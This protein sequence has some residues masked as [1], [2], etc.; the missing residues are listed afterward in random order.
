MAGG[1]F[2]G[3]QTPPLRSVIEA[4]TDPDLIIELID[5]LSEWDDFEVFKRRSGDVIRALLRL[6]ETEYTM[7]FDGVDDI[8]RGEV[9]MPDFKS[10]FVSEVRFYINER[11][12]GGFLYALHDDGEMITGARVVNS[13]TSY[14]EVV[15][16]ELDSY[17]KFRSPGFEPSSW[18]DLKVKYSS[19]EVEIEVDGMENGFPVSEL[20]FSGA[21][22]L[23]IG[24]RNYTGFLEASINY[25]QLSVGPVCVADI[26]TEADGAIQ[27]DDDSIAVIGVTQR[28]DPGLF[29]ALIQSDFR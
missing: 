22:D 6:F 28:K 3:S 1:A 25:V 27:R 12:D 18:V 7:V 4:I 29:E 15:V 19:R 13:A 17:S 24:A 9:S 8:I 21:Y 5:V 10:G 14:I 2:S 23:T 11:S 26:Q 20:D 16:K